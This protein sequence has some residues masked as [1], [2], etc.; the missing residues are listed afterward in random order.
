MLAPIAGKKAKDSQ[1]RSGRY[2]AITASA[3]SASVISWS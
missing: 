1:P 3:C 2:F